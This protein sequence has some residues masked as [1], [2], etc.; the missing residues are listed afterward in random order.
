MVLLVLLSAPSSQSERCFLSVTSELHLF[1][2]LFIYLLFLC[3]CLY[4]FAFVQ[5]SQ[6]NSPFIGWNIFANLFEFMCILN[7]CG[8]WFPLLVFSFPFHYSGV[9][10][11]ARQHCSS[12]SILPNCTIQL[13]QNKQFYKIVIYSFR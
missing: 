2:Y 10:L 9:K 11:L 5:I 4:L 6:S 1:I 7:C 8:D 12:R 3:L 13:K